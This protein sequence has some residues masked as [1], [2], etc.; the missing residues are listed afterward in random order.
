MTSL[1]AEFVTTAVDAANAARS[2]VRKYFRTSLEVASKL[3]RSPV[4][5]A[6]RETEETMRDLIL[7]R[8]PGH[9]FFGEEGGDQSADKEWRWIIDPID[10]T[11]SFATGKPTFGTLVALLQGELPV[12]GI[13]DHAMLDERWIGIHGQPTTFNGELCRT[14]QVLSLEQ[15]TVNTTTLDMFDDQSFQQ[16]S[17]L[18]QSCKFRIFGGDCYCY[19]LAASGYTDLV[20]EADLYPYDYFAL[21]PV[22]QGAGGV[23]SDWQGKPLSMNSGDQVI[24]AAN[25]TLH[26]LAVE[27]LNP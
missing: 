27:K 17:N 5:I 13:I 23:I 10:G 9:G 24:A 22:L 8:H 2:I 16:Y 3:D 7:A 12:I 21:I 15:A 25:S 20:C 4:T 6:D 26:Q 14:S 11:K 19:G 18:S 1:P